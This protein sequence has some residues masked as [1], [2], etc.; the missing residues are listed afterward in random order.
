MPEGNVNAEIADHLREHGGHQEAARSRRRIETI[1][2]LEAIL[3]AMVAV[4]TAWSG[5]QAAKWD[6]VSA[7]EYATSSRLRA[8][9]NEQQLTSNQT[10]I[11]NSGT[12]T[13][14]LQAGATGE[15][16]LAA[17]LANRFTPDYKVAFDAWVKT[18]P[19]NNPKAPPG[20]RY[21]PQYKDPLAA[22]A[23]E[24]NNQASEAFDAGVE[25][26]DRAEHYVRVTVLLA[27]VLFLIALGQRFTVRG[28]RRAML[29]VAGVFLVYTIVLLLTYPRA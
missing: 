19:V 27:A 18:D 3:L 26:R 7:R 10:L 2:I 24:L 14:W 1:E 29:S 6:G 20:P 8:E 13:A 25:S 16:K 21:M 17:L 28:V 23:T 9:G 4:V 12:L 5:Y 22:K 11:Y 15:T